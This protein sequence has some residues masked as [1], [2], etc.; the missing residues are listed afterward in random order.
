ME[1]KYEALII[2]GGPAGLSAAL[3]LARMGRKALI[4]D[5]GRPR[6]AP[7]GHL[8]N[9]PTRD[10]IHPEE[11]REAAR[12]DLSKYGTAEA[13][14]GAVKSVQKI[15]EGFSAELSDGRSVRAR[16]VILAYGVV[17]QLPESEGFKELWGKSIFH[18]PYCHGHEARGMKLGLVSKGEM[19]FHVLA[20]VSSLTSDLILFTDGKAQFTEEQLGWLKR[21]KIEWVE[22]PIRDLRHEGSTLQAVNLVSGASRERDAL[23]M[24]P[25]LPF[26][27]KSDIGE[28]LGCARNPMGLYQVNERMETSVPGVFAAGDCATPAH[29]VLQ[30]SASGSMAGA[31]A[32]AQ[33]LDREFKL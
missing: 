4:C 32:V 24:A 7:S 10:G 25:S 21:R 15:D 6:N 30:A 12:A 29:S 23:F 18:C 33:I 31:A 13:F 17:D 28:K 3:S 11:W 8:N 22:E 9:F 20:L 26:R 14:Q 1:S 19:T 5:D 2:G 16:K 27:L